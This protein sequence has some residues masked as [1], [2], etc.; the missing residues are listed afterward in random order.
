MDLQAQFGGFTWKPPKAK[1]VTAAEMPKNSR[2]AKALRRQATKVS[3][4]RKMRLTVRGMSRS[5]IMRSGRKPLHRRPR[6]FAIEYT[7]TNTA[8]DVPPPRASTCAVNFEWSKQQ[9]FFT[10]SHCHVSA[11]YE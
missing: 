10:F 3:A 8:V 1:P 7:D 2:R 6:Q 5:L 11:D 4:E 9:V